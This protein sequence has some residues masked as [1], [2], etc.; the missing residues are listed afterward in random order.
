MSNWQVLIFF[1]IIFFITLLTLILVNPRQRFRKEILDYLSQ[2][3]I[4]E[5][6]K[7]P[8]HQTYY[9]QLFWK[10]YHSKFIQRCLAFFQTDKI[11]S[12][13]TKAGRYDRIEIYEYLLLKLEFLVAG[14]FLSIVLL[15]LHVFGSNWVINYIFVI[16]VLLL[17]F[18]FPN[19]LL[20]QEIYRYREQLHKGLPD[21]LELA[22]LCFAAG[23]TVDN[24]IKEGAEIFRD[25]NTPLAHELAIT[26]AELH[27]YSNR[28][29]AWRNLAERTQLD[30]VTSVAQLFREHERTGIPIV[31]L[32]YNHAD[33]L[34]E[35]YHHQVE[36]QI[37]KK[38]V[39]MVFCVQLLAL[40][41]IIFIIAALLFDLSQLTTS[42]LQ[43][44]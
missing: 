25:I 9:R 8:Q 11:A 7:S 5:K 44:L 20:Q 15:K 36:R 16:G 26:Y 6:K 34:R 38:P 37:E 39:Y 2:D 12:N 19:L 4:K 29:I 1:S 42:F 13:L 3:K 32:L 43:G 17:F 31:A 18:Y 14:I 27:W 28:D 21:F 35:N 22:A 30:D 23:Y 10:S 41:M 33:R 40:P 24:T